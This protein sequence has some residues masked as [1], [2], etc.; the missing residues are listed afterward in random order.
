VLRVFTG[1]VGGQ[2][3]WLLSAAVCLLVV[4]WC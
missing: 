2:V 4:G 3:A 1:E